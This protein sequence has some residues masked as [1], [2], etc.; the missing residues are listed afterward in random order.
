[1]PN[2]CIISIADGSLLRRRNSAAR[3]TS[4]QPNHLHLIDFLRIPEAISAALRLPA[5]SVDPTRS[6]FVTVGSQTGEAFVDRLKKAWTVQT[7]PLRAF[8]QSCAC[9]TADVRF[10]TI[11]AWALGRMPT[12]KPD[13]TVVCIS[14]DP[15]L[16]MP[17]RFARELGIDARLAWVDPLGEEASFFA[18]S[19]HVPVVK[20]DTAMLIANSR[21]HDFTEALRRGA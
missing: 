20:L 2:S 4:P 9:G 8:K 16:V 18:D 6:Y 17:L 13:Q 11:L 15:A 1:M 19:N 5:S 10:S 12:D 3:S 7:F 14:N 21:P